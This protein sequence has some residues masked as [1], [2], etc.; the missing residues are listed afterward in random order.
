MTATHKGKSQAGVSVKIVSP[1][2]KGDISGIFSPKTIL[3]TSRSGGPIQGPMST[4]RSAVIK[5]TGAAVRQ[6]SA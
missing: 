6:N 1:A 4:G 2:S 3:N 5:S